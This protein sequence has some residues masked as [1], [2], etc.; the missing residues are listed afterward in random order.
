M[1]A[2]SPDKRFEVVGASSLGQGA[3]LVGH[4]R[5]PSIIRPSAERLGKPIAPTRPLAHL[6]CRWSRK[7]YLLRLHHSIEASAVQLFPLERFTD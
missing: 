5:L 7:N 6:P 3:P 1:A 4:I 2:S